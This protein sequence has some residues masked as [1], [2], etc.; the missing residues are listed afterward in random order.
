MVQC[1]LCQKKKQLAPRVRFSVGQTNQ[2]LT[3]V[4]TAGAKGIDLMTASAR[5]KRR[6]S[7]K[8]LQ[9]RRSTSRALSART[10]EIKGAGRTSNKPK[11]HGWHGES[12][13]GTKTAGAIV[14]ISFIALSAVVK[15]RSNVENGYYEE[16][17]L[18]FGATKHV[19]PDGTEM[20]DYTPAESGTTL[21]S[22]GGTFVP[23]KGVGDIDFRSIS[24]GRGWQNSNAEK[25]GARARCKGESVLVENCGQNVG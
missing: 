1:Q 16:W 8:T 10:T 3:R 18:D 19:T 14:I 23:V 6:G 17:Q 5:R 24:V 22:I 4:G 25:S 2:R 12:E 21:E 7:R 15:G 13:V 9:T 20:A 11:A